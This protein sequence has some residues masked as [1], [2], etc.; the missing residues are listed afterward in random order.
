MKK[1][2]IKQ[3]GY[4]DLTIAPA[5]RYWCPGCK[6]MH[7]IPTDPRG[8]PNGHKWAFDG[9]LDAPTFQPSVHLVGRCHHFIRAGRIEYCGDSKHSLAGQTVDMIDLES[10]SEDDW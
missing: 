3:V 4:S 5:W 2:K 8:Q 7:I 1:M 9:N 6:W 10:I